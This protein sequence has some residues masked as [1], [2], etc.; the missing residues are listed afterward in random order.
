MRSHC[1][2]TSHT[3]THIAQPPRNRIEWHIRSTMCRRVVDLMNRSLFLAIMLVFQLCSLKRIN[4]CGMIYI[5]THFIN[6]KYIADSFLSFIRTVASTFFLSVVVFFQHCLEQI[7]SG[8][9][10]Q[11]AHDKD[12]IVEPQKKKLPLE[13]RYK[14]RCAL[15]QNPLKGKS[16]EWNEHK[17]MCM[18]ACTRA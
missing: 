18:T 3:H 2:I 4:V 10:L 13:M 9:L 15:L 1:C 12:I 5:H 6:A 16:I 14:R 8:C 17:T 11:N 7:C